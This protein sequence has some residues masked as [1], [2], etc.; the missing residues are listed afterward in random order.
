[1][2]ITSVFNNIF[3]KGYMVSNLKKISLNNGQIIG[4]FF[5]FTFFR[6]NLTNKSK[7]NINLKIKTIFTN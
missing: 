4:V 2:C 7:K 1:M 5:F 3:T 6:I